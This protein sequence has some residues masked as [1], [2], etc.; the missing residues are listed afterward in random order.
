M[1]LQNGNYV[2]GKMKERIVYNIRGEQEGY[3]VKRT[4][5]IRLYLCY[6]CGG[7]SRLEVAKRAKKCSGNMI[8]RPTQYNYIQHYWPVGCT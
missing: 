6:D 4:S 7:R 1:T 2:H 8:G 5:E 3:D